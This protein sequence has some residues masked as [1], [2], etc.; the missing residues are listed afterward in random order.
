MRTFAV[1]SALVGVVL[2][3]VGFVRYFAYTHI[4]SGGN[5]A[6]FTIGSIA[7]FAGIV[8]GIAHWST[9]RHLP[10]HRNHP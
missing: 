5:I 10:T 9:R 4:M 8:L 2:L 1:L 7:L 3:V 6:L